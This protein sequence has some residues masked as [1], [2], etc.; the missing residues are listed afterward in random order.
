MPLIHQEDAV[1]VEEG[2]RDGGEVFKAVWWPNQYVEVACELIAV[3]VVLEFISDAYCP[4]SDYAFIMTVDCYLFRGN[5]KFGDHGGIFEHVILEDMDAP[6][7]ILAAL[8]LHLLSI[9]R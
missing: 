1:E 5:I 6:D 4:T 8:I 9:A 2:L 7:D 3:N